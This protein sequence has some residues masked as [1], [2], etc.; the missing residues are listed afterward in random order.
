M[1]NNVLFILSDEHA[2]DISGCYGNRI[3]RTPNIDA[4]SSRG[5]TFDSAYCNSPIC[6]PSRAS[7]ATGNYVHRIR[8]WDNAHPYDGAI[9]SWHHNLRNAGHE[10]VSIGKLHYRS[11]DDDDGFSQTI[12]PIYVPDGQGDVIGL[13]RRDPQ[14]RKAA[15]AMAA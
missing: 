2:R 11:A 9:P 13:L 1:A 10:V 4:L 5:V 3:V 12:H 14:P 6:V 8:Y 15:R 7:L